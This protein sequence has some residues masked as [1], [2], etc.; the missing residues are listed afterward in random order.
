[1]SE[2]ERADGLGFPWW[3]GKW[4][5]NPL[6]EPLPRVAAADGLPQMPSYAWY[7][8]ECG[9]RNNGFDRTCRACMSHADGQEVES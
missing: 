2:N 9:A 6:P 3:F 7:C 4:K 5:P 1:M 8:D